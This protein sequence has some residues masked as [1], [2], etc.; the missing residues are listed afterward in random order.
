MSA[1]LE[2]VQA[3]LYQEADL[4]DRHVYSDWL[5]LW[6]EDAVYWIPCNDD[7]ADPQT[8]VALIYETRSGLEDRVRRLSS[9]Y[10]HSQ[11]PQ[12]RLSRVVANIRTIELPDGLVEVRSVCNITAFRRQIIETLAAR[13]VHRLR[14]YGDG[15]RIVSK[16]VY[17][18]NNDGY[19]G[20]MTF[21]I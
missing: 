10:A 21:L 8:H 14:P 19:I 1:L 16:T 5:A 6:A 2:R 7:D 17:L 15:F 18:V 20:N 3:F 13:V 11:N 12:T 4:A 9:G